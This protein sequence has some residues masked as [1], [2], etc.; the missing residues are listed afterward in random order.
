MAVWKWWEEKAFLNGGKVEGNKC[1]FSGNFNTPM[2]DIRYKILGVEEGDT[3]NIFAETNK[4]R[5]KLEGK[6]IK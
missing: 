2:G 1:I 6:K 3:L 5:I 4:G